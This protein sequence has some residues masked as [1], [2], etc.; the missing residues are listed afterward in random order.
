MDISGTYG[1]YSIEV[2]PMNLS[3]VGTYQ[4]KA[5]MKTSPSVCKIGDESE[6]TVFACLPDY[7]SGPNF[8]NLTTYIGNNIFYLVKFFWTKGQTDS[9]RNS[10]KVTYYCLVLINNFPYYQNM[11]F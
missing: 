11:D 8:Q 5:C 4:L 7:L 9:W 3:Q 6:I 2:E 10:S 1:D